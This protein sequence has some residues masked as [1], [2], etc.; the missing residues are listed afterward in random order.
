M[1]DHRLTEAELRNLPLESRV[2][3]PIFRQRIEEDGSRPFLSVD[4]NQFTYGEFGTYTLNLARGLSRLEVGEGQIVPILAHNCAPYIAAWFAVH[5]RGATI[6]LLNPGLKSRM[7]ALALADCRP[8]I[9]IAHDEAIDSIV[10]LP[11]AERSGLE[12]I[13]RIA[14]ANNSSRRMGDPIRVIEFD[15]LV[16]GNGPDPIVETRFD[17]V[18]T[19]F[20]TSG[21]TGPAKGVLMP[22][23]HY[24]AN[25]CS[26]IRLTGLNRDD[27]VHTSLPLFHGV[28]SRQGVLPA[29]MLGAQVDVGLKFSGSRFWDTVRASKATVALLTPTMP[30][31]I[32]AHAPSH[33]D[34][35]HRLRALYNVSPDPAIEERFGLKMFVSF[36]I[37]EIGVV[38][39]SR[40]DARRLGTMGQAHE[41]WDL[42]IVD[43]T[44]RP[45]PDGTPGELVCR[46]RRPFIMMQ[47]YL[48]RPEAAASAWRNLWYH[49]GDYM[50]RDAEGWYRFAGRNKDRIRRRGENIS[51]LQIEDELRIHPRVQD[52]VA[53]GYPAGDGED[54]IRLAIIVRQGAPAGIFPELAQWLAT[55][56]PPT[57]IPRYWEAFSEFPVTPTGKV[58]R[59]AL[60]DFPLSDTVWDRTVEPVPS[61]APACDTN[62]VLR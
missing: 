35:D 41:D 30:P 9:I 3:G 44:D 18:Q 15:S 7:L 43:D 22:N 47:G 8:R 14:S 46:P 36:A 17:Q 19:V 11:E 52:A 26:M 21:S 34:R 60:R 12:C 20:F 56:L 61:H 32:S 39:Y 31:L 57:M 28:G 45:V 1:S 51:P 37:T 27:I 33:R 29:F 62:F 4:G 25:P 49:T 42:K 48:N 50:V 53:L 6:A 10:D 16:D 2:F 40:P 58:D 5:L 54:D 24:F 38:I 55:R 13:I 23:A 59:Q